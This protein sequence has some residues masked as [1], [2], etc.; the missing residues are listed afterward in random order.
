MVPGR[1]STEVKVFRIE[2][3]DHRKDLRDG[4]QLDAHD[5]CSVP[6]V[7]KPARLKAG[8]NPTAATTGLAQDRKNSVTPI[9][10]YNLRIGFRTQWLTNLSACSLR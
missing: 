3:R 7:K 5:D 4:G 2:C 10:L 9:V 1:I 6:A 8:V